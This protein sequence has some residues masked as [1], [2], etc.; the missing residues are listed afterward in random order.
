MTEQDFDSQLRRQ[1]DALPRQIQPQRDLWA[2]IDVALTQQS[3]QQDETPVKVPHHRGLYALAASLMVVAITAWLTLSPAPQQVTGEQLVNALSEQHQS[4]VD[5]LLVKFKD[6][7]A[8]T[9]NW[10]QQLTQLDEAAI[11][12]KAALEQ[13]PDN[14]ALLRMLQNVYQ[15]QIELIERVHAPKWQAI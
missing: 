12:I 5:S 7:P 8:L 15:Q 10:Q 9:N 3:M 2:G 11:A 1:I 14:V 13:D 4:Q 6:Q